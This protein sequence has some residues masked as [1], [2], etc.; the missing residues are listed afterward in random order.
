MGFIVWFPHRA[1][2]IRG[3]GN[4]MAWKRRVC[5]TMLLLVE[6][7]ALPDIRQNVARHRYEFDTEAGAALAFYRLHD[8][9]MTFTHTEVPAALRGRGIGSAMMR[10]VLDDA[11]A[12]GLKVVAACPFVADYIGRHAEFAGLLART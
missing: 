1:R 3:G 10:A 2:R 7:L 9:V 5:H 4:E 12:Q 6:E 8:G 11:R